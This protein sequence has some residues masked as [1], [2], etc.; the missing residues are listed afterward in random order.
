MKATNIKVRLRRCAVA[1]LLTAV[2]LGGALTSARD[3]EQPPTEPTSI[4][5]LVEAEAPISVETSRITVLVS[6]GEEPQAFFGEFL[7]G[8]TYVSINEF[9][10]ALNAAYALGATVTQPSALVT[11]YAAAMPTALTA[12]TELVL[13]AA[14]LESATI[15]LG[16]D[17]FTITVG[18]S[19]VSVGGRYIYLAQ[20]ATTLNG[21]LCVPVRPLA[22]ALGADIG[23]NEDF[24]T[25]LVAQRTEPTSAAPYSDEDLHWMAR[26]ITAE[27]R[28]ESF[29]GKLAVGNV[30]MNR[31]AD[32]AFPKSVY[33]VIFDNAS[34]V[35]FT[36][37][38]SGAIY[39]TPPADCVA[40]ADIALRRGADIVGSSLYFASTAKCW[41]A[42]NREHYATIGAHDFYI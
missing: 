35:Q 38:Y 2:T 29:E 6:G 39:N 1:L 10:A 34:G 33:N 22:D 13:P 20:G 16:N 28:G 12:P 4:E 40:A 8:A 9:V 19:Y 31:V 25:V 15:T 18:D 30:I 5:L 17:T 7:N 23:W 11:D 42:R 26:I 27:A 14:M 36:P 24:R 41:A 37:A 3:T 21:E 32:E